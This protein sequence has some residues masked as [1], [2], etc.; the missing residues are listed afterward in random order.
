ML[1]VCNPYFLRHFILKLLQFRCELNLRFVIVSHVLTPPLFLVSL[2]RF[3][4]SGRAFIAARLRF[5]LYF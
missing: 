1:A 4:L 5:S 2:N 3:V